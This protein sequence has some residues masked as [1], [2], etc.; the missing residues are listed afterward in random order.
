MLSAPVSLYHQQGSTMPSA[1]PAAHSS[2]HLVPFASMGRECPHARLHDHS[3][4]L[5]APS[6]RLSMG[7]MPSVSKLAFYQ[8]A[9]LAAP[10]DAEVLTDLKA[11][12]RDIAYTIS[13]GRQVPDGLGVVHLAR[14]MDLLAGCLCAIEALSKKLDRKKARRRGW[15]L[16]CSGIANS[17]TILATSMRMGL[18]GSWTNSRTSRGTLHRGSCVN[19][20]CWQPLPFSHI[21]PWGGVLPG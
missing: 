9:R 13:K 18:E 3:Y 20:R 6:P 15:G 12:S 17:I 7:K 10:L 16:Q 4:G 5:M 1:A 14:H 2:R 19:S 8:P 11:T 21:E